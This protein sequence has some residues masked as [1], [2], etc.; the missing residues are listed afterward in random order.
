M[1]NISLERY[2]TELLLV[3]VAFK[4]MG[5]NGEMKMLKFYIHWCPELW[6]CFKINCLQSFG[7]CRL[8]LLI[9]EAK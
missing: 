6:I 8:I 2:L 9:T 5:K 1:L 4:C 3:F 7:K